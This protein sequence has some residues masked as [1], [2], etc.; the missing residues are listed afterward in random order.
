MFESG[1]AYAVYRPGRAHHGA[2]RHSLS[3][4]STRS[5]VAPADEPRRQSSGTS[6]SLPGPGAFAGAHGAIGKDCAIDVSADTARIEESARACLTSVG[7]TDA[8]WAP[9]TPPGP[10]SETEVPED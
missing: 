1:T 5:G 8:P 9:V 6:V 4:A 7:L 10:G 2:V 3:V